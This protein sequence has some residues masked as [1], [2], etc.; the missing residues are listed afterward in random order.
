MFLDFYVNDVEN[1]MVGQMLII[2]VML[3]IFNGLLME[4]SYG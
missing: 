3:D 4:Y 2:G 1:V